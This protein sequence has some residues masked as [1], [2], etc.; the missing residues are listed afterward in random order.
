MILRPNEIVEGFHT[1]YMKI[2]IN[3]VY[4]N[5]I[6]MLDTDTGEYE[7][8]DMTALPEPVI[9]SGKLNKL[10]VLELRMEKRF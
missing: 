2:F 6:T 10:D 1:L 9:V 7:A 3:G 4:K 8:W 5:T